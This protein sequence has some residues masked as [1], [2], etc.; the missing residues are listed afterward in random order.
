MV[1]N[2]V[3]DQ[4]TVFLSSLVSTKLIFLYAFIRLF[5]GKLSS[6]FSWHTIFSFFSWTVCLYRPLGDRLHH[7]CFI[8]QHTRPC[9]PPHVY[10]AVVFL[11]IP[12]CLTFTKE[13]NLFALEVILFM[14]CF[15]SAIDIG[16]SFKIISI[17]ASTCFTLVLHA[18]WINP[19]V[20]LG[21]V[22]F[23]QIRNPVHSKLLKP[24]Y[25]VVVFLFIIC[26]M[27]SIHY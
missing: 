17:I 18:E 3:Q 22:L 23:P 5:Y 21:V 15:T 4:T 12:S 2:V 19:F 24:M 16:R 14:C 13:E 20:F 9:V 26:C 1:C 25:F 10:Q 27:G 6:M 11:F 8:V 7:R